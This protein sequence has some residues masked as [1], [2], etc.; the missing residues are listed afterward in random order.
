MSTI[1]KR[2]NRQFRNQRNNINLNNYFNI[3]IKN[4]I[5]KLDYI[6]DN[7]FYV[8][9]NYETQKEYEISFIEL[10][11]EINRYINEFLKPIKVE[12]KFLVKYEQNPFRPSKWTLFNF[13]TNARHL[14]NFDNYYIHI[15]DM[16][17]HYYNIDSSNWSVFLTV[18]KDILD[19]LVRLNLNHI[20]KMFSE[21]IE[22]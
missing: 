3:N 1:I 11:T 21:K 19:F 7:N 9:V 13:S 4:C 17:N 16:R 22:F 14:R 6:E 20:E 2:F 5:L 8:T 12:V 10:P 15:T 18:D